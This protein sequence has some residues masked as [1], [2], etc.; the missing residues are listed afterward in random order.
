MLGAGLAGVLFTAGIAFASLSLSSRNT[1]GMQCY[2]SFKY[3]AFDSI[4]LAKTSI[5][6]TKHLLLYGS[7]ILVLICIIFELCYFLSVE[8]S[9]LFGGLNVPVPLI[10]ILC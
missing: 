6:H 5:I 8:V 3:C 1:S 9:S 7:H 4:S 2:L 10:Y